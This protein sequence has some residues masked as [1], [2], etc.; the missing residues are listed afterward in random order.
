MV[1]GNTIFNIKWEWIESTSVPRPISIDTT[2][3]INTN[4]FSKYNEITIRKMDQEI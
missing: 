3:N 2:V 1:D 4:M